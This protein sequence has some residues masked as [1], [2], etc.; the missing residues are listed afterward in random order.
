[1]KYSPSWLRVFGTKLPRYR[2]RAG[3]QIN[4]YAAIFF[5]LLSPTNAVT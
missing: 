1:M 2:G 3:A 5:V 4:A